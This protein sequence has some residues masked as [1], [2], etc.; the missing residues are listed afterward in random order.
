MLADDPMESIME[1]KT[2]IQQM[3][4]AAVRGDGPGVV[5]CFCE[6]GIYHDV[7]YGEFKGS[8]IIHLIEDHFHRDGR[9]F[10]W[11]LYDPIEQNG[12]GYA[13]YVFSYSSKLPQAQDRRATF[14][15]VAICRLEDGLISEYRE[16]ANAVIGLH[17]LGFSPERL[18]RFV[19]RE[20]KS[21]LGR[22]DDNVA[23][24]K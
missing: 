7:F 18:S 16:V 12:I 9:D 17:L 13:R 14:E 5:A 4:Q 15:G 22:V 11:D 8:A 20:A 19:D 6:N 23:Q 1:F 2:L 10:R 3:T 21:L 24:S